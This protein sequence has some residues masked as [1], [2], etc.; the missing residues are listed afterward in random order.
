MAEARHASFCA[1]EFIRLARKFRVAVV[2]ADSE[3][4]PML[5]DV[6]SDFVYARLQKAQASLA[7]GYSPADI[8]KWAKRAKTWSEGGNAEDLVLVGANAPKKKRDVFVYMING[9]KERAPAAAM[10][11]LERVR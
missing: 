7:T 9:A 6:T 5:A 2:V 8:E 4:Y 3:K 11:F 1:P 10:A